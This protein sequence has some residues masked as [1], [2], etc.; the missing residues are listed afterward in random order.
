MRG[1]GMLFL[2]VPDS[3]KEWLKMQTRGTLAS[4]FHFFFH[5]QRP[6]IYLNV[7]NLSLDRFIFELHLNV[8]ARFPD[9]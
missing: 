7:A 6:H 2:Q 4:G 8:V 5:L 9:C 1:V 3:V